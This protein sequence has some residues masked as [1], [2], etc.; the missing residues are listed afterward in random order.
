MEVKKEMTSDTS[1]GRSRLVVTP[2]M[3]NVMFKKSTTIPPDGE[4]EGPWQ[5]SIAGSIIEALPAKVK[6]ALVSCQALVSNECSFMLSKPVCSA[7]SRIDIASSF[8]I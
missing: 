7:K 8:T 4:N 3:G 6:T 5:S 2:E 1:G